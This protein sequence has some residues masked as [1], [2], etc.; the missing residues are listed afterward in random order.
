MQILRSNKI[1]RRL[2]KT[3]GTVKSIA[4]LNEGPWR[5]AVGIQAGIAIG[6]PVALFTFSGQQSYGLIASLG[7]LISLYGT[8]HNTAKRLQL[9]PFVISGMVLSSFCGVLVAGN[10][11]LAGMGIV[12]IAILFS[13]LSFGTGL[14]PPG[15]VIFILV[16]AISARLGSPAIM[17]GA[18]M[19]GFLVVFLITMGAILAY[20]CIIVLSG[21]PYMRKIIPDPETPVLSWRIR[22]DRDMKM[23]AARVIIAVIIA[24]II[25]RPLGIQRSYWV[26]VA[27]AAIL[28]AGNDRSL[29]TVRAIQRVLGT[30]LGVIVFELIHRF[31]P[32]G[33]WVI[34]IVVLFQ[35][36][37]QVVITR[38]YVLGLIFITPLAL[39]NSTVGHTA[40]AAVTVRERILDTIF[41]AGIALVVFW[42]EELISRFNKKP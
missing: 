5:W 19:P 42:V 4:E 1:R 25:S 18:G 3:K 28:Q 2:V 13:I 10:V 14:G 30:L 33:I 39:V 27:A 21:I 41:G 11:W 26:I 12:L 17:G 38:N 22:M 23:V 32:S 6:I 40:S 34:V 20:L 24:M 8:K 9:L 31:H 35:F 29:T 36:G 37:T 7:G 16:T 15:P